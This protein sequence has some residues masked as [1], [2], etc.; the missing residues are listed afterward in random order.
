MPTRFVWILTLCALAALRLGAEEPKP[1]TPKPEAPKPE[2]PK[3]ADDLS[4][5]IKALAKDLASERA[6]VRAK[7]EQGLLEIGAPA[8]EDLKPLLQGENKDAAAAVRRLLESPAFDPTNPRVRITL[9]GG[10]TIEIVLLEDMAPNTVANFIE[11]TE[12]H[13]YDGLTF[14]RI[15]ENFMV[16][17][18]DPTGTGKGGPGYAIADEINADDLGID[19]VTAKE[20]TEKMG[21]KPPPPSV[22]DLSLKAIYEKQGFKY[23]TDIRSLKVTRGV[24]AMANYGPNTGASQFFITHIDCPWL[25]GKHTVFGIVTK[26]MEFVD[27]MRPKQKM[28]RVDVLSKR[29]HKYKAKKLEEK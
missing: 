4:V 12:K 18:G 25:D 5:R 10:G 17:G 8:A 26:G 22:A 15:V 20:L 28:E 27:E 21:G 13:Y 7:A 23:R 2:A 16:Q 14:H 3:P 24:L 1:E 6:D 9:A 29:D 11:L 19:K